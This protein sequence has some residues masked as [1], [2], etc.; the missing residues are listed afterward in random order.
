MAEMRPFKGLLYNS[1]EAGDMS[2][3]MAPPYDV[4]SPEMRED[5]YR[6][7]DFNIVKLILGKDLPEDGGSEN[8]YV[9]SKKFME[10][11]IERRVLVADPE[12]AFYV[13]LQQYEVRGVVTSRIGFLGLMKIEGT[14]VVLPHEHT[15]S[16]PKKDRMMLIQEVKSNLSPIFGLYGGDEGYVSGM[17]KN[18]V[19]SSTPVIDIEQDGVKHVLW[20]LSDSDKISEIVKTMEGRKIFIADGHHRYAVAKAYRDTC[21]D[22]AG[23][24]GRADHVLMYLTDMSDP[25]NLTVLATHRV[26]KDVSS[27]AGGDISSSLEKYFNLTRFDSLDELMNE[28]DSRSQKS[29]VYG[30]YDGGKFTLLEPVE[31]GVLRDLIKD[32]P[33]SWKELDVSVLHSAV[34]EKV[35]GVKAGEGDIAYVKDPHEA[36]RIVNNDSGKAAFFLNPTKIGQLKAVAEEGEMM[37]QKSTYFYPKLLTGLVLNRFEDQKEKVR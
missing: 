31:N 8:K 11:W 3:V 14:D 9:R 19:S 37:P 20:R 1:E 26:I 13:Y 29:Y 12:D 4:I 17:L 23:Y 35:L 6:K 34:F 33:E 7:S 5:L 21:R 10:E 24:D 25:D 15:L 32:K 36:E 22:Q 2:E 28:M 27:A 30:F 18:A 16:K